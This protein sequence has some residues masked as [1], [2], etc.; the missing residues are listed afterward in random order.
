MNQHL[1]ELQLFAL[2]D[3]TEPME[4]AHL[5]ACADCRNEF[6]S[7]CDTLTNFRSAASS[8]SVANTPP[9]LN[10]R[11]LSSEPQRHDF[12]T[13]RR[14]GWTA[15]LV[16]AMA[17]CT[18]SVGILRKPAQAPVTVATSPASTDA[19]AP[20]DEAL[21][22]DVDRDLSTSVPPSLAPLETTTS[23]GEK[24]ITSN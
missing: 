22:D 2:L 12:F 11:L 7:L 5:L 3:A 23:A 6:A 17:L 19:P 10:T 13:L 14:A 8:F 15:G 21:L 18:A 1:N 9:R 20:S 16:T 24:T 4:D